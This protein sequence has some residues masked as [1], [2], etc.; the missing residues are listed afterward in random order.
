M[1]EEEHVLAPY[2]WSGE[3]PVLGDISVVDSSS[4]R[5]VSRNAKGISLCFSP[6]TLYADVGDFTCVSHEATMAHIRSAV[7]KIGLF[8]D[9]YC[10]SF[11]KIQDIDNLKARY[12]YLAILR[13]EI[14]KVNLLD[15]N[16]AL[17]DKFCPIEA[18]IAALVGSVEKSMTVVIYEDSRFIRIIGAKNGMIY[19]LTTIN[20]R[21]SF[22]VI[23]DTISGI[24]EMNSLLRV[25]FQESANK[26]YKIG[27]IRVRA[28]DLNERGIHVEPFNMD[29]EG[30]VSPQTAVLFGCVTNTLYDFTP[31]RFLQTKKIVRH[32]KV[33]MAISLT[34]VL[35]SGVLLILGWNNTQ[36]AQGYQ[37]QIHSAI[38]K[39]SQDLKVLE[40]DYVSLSRELDLSKIN[41]IIKAYQDFEA[42]PKLHAIVDTISQRIPD[43]VF[44][45][46]IDV[47]RPTQQEDSPQARIIQTAANAPHTT[48]TDSLD[49]VIEGIINTPYPQSKGI[50]SSLTAAIQEV[51]VVNS[52]TFSQKE[53]S[54]GFT[55]K[56]EIKL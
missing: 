26:I 21:E 3:R 16:E 49:V 50:F 24:H 29:H 52:A 15:E 8:K 55:L 53:Q 12:S 4:L 10:I 38:Y 5:K 42:Q 7:D 34:L 54:A 27:E 43:D 45:T 25:S 19:Y 32:A 13:T 47:S 37:K 23:A 6:R 36:I 9:D 30:H 28:N 41:K 20:A 44:I 56:C 31:E 39:N 2:S 18:A 51:F 1:G 48:H 46:N 40:G 22:D 35:I 11:T 33:S 14:N 17:I